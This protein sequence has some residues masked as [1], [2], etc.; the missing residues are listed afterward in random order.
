MAEL[1]LSE[2]AASS[3]WSAR[4]DGEECS[5]AGASL[6]FELSFLFGGVTLKM[7]ALFYIKNLIS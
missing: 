7:L 2:S 1:S 3:R 6:D 5:G 4:R